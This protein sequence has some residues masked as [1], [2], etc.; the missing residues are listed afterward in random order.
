MFTVQQI[1]EIRKKLALQSKKDSDFI[2]VT[3]VDAN[4]YITLI[5]DGKNVKVKINNLFNISPVEY[6]TVK[7]IA[8][9]SNSV[10]ILNGINTDNI[11]VQKGSNIS[12]LVYLDGY[13]TFYSNL[14]ASE[15][16]TLEVVLLPLEPQC[17]TLTINPIP[18]SANV[19]LNGEAKRYITTLRGNA[20]HVVVAK[21]GYYTYSEYIIVDSNKTETIVLKPIENEKVVLTVKAIPEDS[22]VSL[23]GQ[24]TDSI[25]VDK[26]SS[27]NIL[28]S[29][30]G[31][32]SYSNTLVVNDDQTIN[33]VLNKIVTTN[34]TL[35]VIPSPTDANVYLNG[36]L[37]REITLPVNSIVNIVVSRTGYKS[38]NNSIT[39]TENKTINVNLVPESVEKV[40]ITISPTPS[41][42]N[43]YLNDV[44]QSSITVDKNSTVKV[45]VYKE[46]YNEYNGTVLAD[47]TKT[48]PIELV[49]VG[50]AYIQVDPTSFNL[51]KEQGTSNLKVTSNISW[52]SEIN[53]IIENI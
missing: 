29:K 7:V 27:V 23:N 52:E 14:V 24:L 20:V 40:T 11:T 38:Y 33:V 31:Y 43:V 35:N 4:D 49:P 44:L 5:K 36:E 50:E 15:D 51:T 32:Y 42:A 45:R 48:V 3:D 46:G 34:V 22:I 13:K 18:S 19:E 47:S 10:V 12:V 16:K 53:N 1:E 17:F 2:E 41:D 30:E 9:P 26:G 37:R 8:N 39:L 21:D 28:V 25:M 6:V